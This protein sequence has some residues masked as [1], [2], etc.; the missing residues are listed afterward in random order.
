MQVPHYSPGVEPKDELGVEPMDELGVEP[1]DELVLGVEPKDELVLGEEPKEELVLGEE[2][3]EELEKEL[4]VEVNRELE[5]SISVYQV[6]TCATR[7][8]SY[9]YF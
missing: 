1:K 6:H 7:N 9:L 5:P 4:G 8:T 2:P 3:K